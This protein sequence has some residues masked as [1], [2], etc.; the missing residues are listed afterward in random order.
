MYVC[1]YIIQFRPL[2]ALRAVAAARARA[3]ASRIDSSSTGG[4]SHTHAHGGSPV[5]Q[6][7]YGYL[8]ETI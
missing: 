8:P 2:H 4:G 6:G 1:M 7:Q 5:T 3:E